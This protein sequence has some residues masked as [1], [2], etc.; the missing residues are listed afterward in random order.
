MIIA[1]FQVKDN[2]NQSRFFQKTFLAT[3]TNVALILGIS[4][5]IL[6][7]ASILFKEREFT[8]QFYIPAKVLSTTKQIEIINHKEFGTVVL[9]PTKEVFIIY[10]VFLVLKLKISIHPAWAI[11]IALLVTKKV[12]I[13]TEHF[14]I[15]DDF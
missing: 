1:S 8:W 15:A 11:Q 10:V 9:D 6:S 12:T 14:N 7:D 5:L 3:K 2:F 13:L 4:F